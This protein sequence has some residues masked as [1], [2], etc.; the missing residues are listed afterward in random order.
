MKKIIISLVVLLLYTVNADIRIFDIDNTNSTV[1]PENIEKTFRDNGFE[2]GINNEMNRPFT[3]QFGKTD[4]KIFN[5]LTIYHP[6]LSMELVNKYPNTGIFVPMSIGIY[7]G[8]NEKD[9]HI[10][11]LSAKAQEKITSVKSPIFAQIED[12]ITKAIM[13]TFPNAKQ[14]ETLE[15]PNPTKPLL[16]MF[17]MKLGNNKPSEDKDTFEMSLESGFEPKGFV[18]PAFI[19]VSEEINK[20]KN[21]KNTYDFYDTYSICKLEV[22]YNV[23]KTKPEAAAFAPCTTVVYKKKGEKK[24][25]VG[26]P[27]VYNWLSSAAVV[28]PE[29]TRVLLKAQNDFET[30]L[31][32]ITE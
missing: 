17:E 30:I 8:T 5:L 32:D 16:T 28:E 15:G 13:T 7:Q 27:S 9:I 1:K 18:M 29:A 26:F 11:V 31:K 6:T 20:N 21:L 23:A 4:Y 14:R 12:K 10:S 3:K 19:N 22:I 24:L 2:V 25:F